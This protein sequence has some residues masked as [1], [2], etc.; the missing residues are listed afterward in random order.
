M[1][2]VVVDHPLITHKLSI[3]RD[4]ETSTK[5]FRE[6]V[7]EITMLLAY[8]A[9]RDF[10]MR[11]VTVETPLCTMQ[12]HKLADEK[13]VVLPILRAGLGMVNGML[14]I[15]PT[16]RVAHVG[17]KRDEE[18][19]LPHTYYYNAPASMSGGRVIILD[20]ML[21]TAGSMCATIDLIKEDAPAE[22][23]A[24]CLLAAPEGAARMD[25]EHPD[26]KVYVGAMD[27]HLNARSYIVPGLGD[28]G[29]RIFG[30][31]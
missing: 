3:L 17:I 9:T 19:A 31:L 26:V 1:P 18:T 28:A 20:P 15:Y 21:A 25:R 4:K 13:L 12:T 16:A 29:D 14:A 10:P 23:S 22:I 8:E 2:V 11:P 7:E 5:K 27:S 6:A 24:V 30:T